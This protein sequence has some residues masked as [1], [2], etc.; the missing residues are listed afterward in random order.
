MIFINNIHVYE[1]KKVRNLK[2][3][4]KKV[5]KN[6]IVGIDPSNCIKHIVL[7]TKLTETMGL[8]RQE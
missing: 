8:V 6:N 1:R 2:T 7:E 3:S 4:M 5:S